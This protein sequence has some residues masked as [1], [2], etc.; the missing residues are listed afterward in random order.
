VRYL[1]HVPFGY[2]VR[3]ANRSA[4]PVALTVRVFLCPVEFD[5]RRTAWIELDKVLHEI[6]AR[7]SSVLYR[8]DSDF[9]VIKRPAET[10]P[11]SVLEG[12]TDP[13]DGNYCVCGW[14]WTLLIPR[15]TP[16]GLPCRLFVIATDAAVD[17]VPAQRHCG[18]MSYCGATDRYPD[19]RDMGYPF[20]RPMPKGPSATTLAHAS[21]AGRSLTIRHESRRSR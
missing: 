12:G 7:K 15:G 3:I 6:P 5:G 2:A 9:S 20:S 1:T 14:P 10:D 4:Q 18:S 16:D 19:S 21:I 13:D 17:Q 8:S 11:G